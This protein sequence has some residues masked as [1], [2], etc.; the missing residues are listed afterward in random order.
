MDRLIS[1]G[2]YKQNR[3]RDSIHSYSGKSQNTF[4][5]YWFLIKL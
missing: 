3:K 5:I 4:C 1:E 2:A